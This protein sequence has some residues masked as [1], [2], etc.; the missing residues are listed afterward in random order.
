MKEGINGDGFDAYCRAI[1]KYPLLSVEEEIELSRIIQGPGD[2]MGREKQEAFFKL[3]SSNFRLVAFCVKE[4]WCKEKSLSKMDLI[5][6]GNKALLSSA[7]HYN[8]AKHKV[9]FNSYAMVSIR[10]RLLD[11]VFASGFIRLP[12]AHNN[13]II[14]LRKIKGLLGYDSIADVSWGD[15][16]RQEWIPKKT[17]KAMNRRLFPKVKRAS[18]IGVASL[19]GLRGPDGVIDPDDGAMGILMADHNIPQASG[20]EKREYMRKILSEITNEKE[21]HLVDQVFYHDVPIKYAALA[22]GRTSQWA[23]LVLAQVF[24]RLKARIVHDK[25]DFEEVPERIA[26]VM[27]G[28]IRPSYRRSRTRKLKNRLEMVFADDKGGK[29]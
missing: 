12:S 8:Y 22:M 2:S 19:D 6:E 10:H 11:A 15:F 23:H 25:M 24:F 18:G 13:C 28:R 20:M 5:Q 4:F 26:K 17:R 3:V 16:Q 14:H 1:G 29:G 27:D 7:A 9:K 21:H